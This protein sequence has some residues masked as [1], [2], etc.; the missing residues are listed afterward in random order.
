M[1]GS[2]GGQGSSHTLGYARR[3]PAP[4][5]PARAL[6]E[7]VNQL[8]RD[9]TPLARAYLLAD[10]RLQLVDSVR[11]DRSHVSTVPRGP[12]DWR[13]RSPR[14]V[15]LQPMQFATVQE[16]FAFVLGFAIV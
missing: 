8:L 11:G 3:F 15:T 13:A 9:L 2:S 4:P 12:A 10:E 1:T 5:S 6:G 16:R 7:R 14:W